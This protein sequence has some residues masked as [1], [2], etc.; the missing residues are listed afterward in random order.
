[1]RIVIGEDSVLLRAG[2]T[3]LLAESRSGEF[4]KHALALMKLLEQTSGTELQRAELYNEL[5]MTAPEGDPQLAERYVAEGLALLGDRSDAP[6]RKARGLLLT[7]RGNMLTRKSEFAASVEPFTQARD[8]LADGFADTTY[9]GNVLSSLGWIEIRFDRYDS[10][11]SYFEQAAEATRRDPTAFPRTLAMRYDDLASAKTLVKRYADAERNFRMAIDVLERSYGRDD[12]ETAVTI[13]K[14]GRALAMQTRYD[15]AIAS[16]REAV[17]ILEKP[18]PHSNA[19]YLANARDFLVVTLLQAGRL[20]EAEPLV[21][22]LVESPV[23]APA[24]DQANMHVVAAEYFAQRGDLASAQKHARA[25]LDAAQAAYGEGNPKLIRFRNR[26]ARLLLV[27]G[28]AEQASQL[29]IA[30]MK[31]DAANEG[32]FDSIWRGAHLTHKQALVFLGRGAQAVPSLERLL[33]QHYAQ[34]KEQQDPV[35]EHAIEL[36]LGRALM[37]AGRQ[38]EAL[39]HLERALGLRQSQY[40]FSPQLAEAKIALADCKLRLGDVNGS[41]ALLA[42]AEAIH[43]ANRALAA[44]YRAPLRNL[45]QRLRQFPRAPT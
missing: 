17:Q 22:R 35:Q 27:L 42:E 8:L 18:H 38:T 14:L 43:A 45:Q 40:R 10:A 25:F 30:N 23:S 1:V 34:P 26:W 4:S 39:P 19:S 21:R 16:L 11:L 24:F 15:E 9:Y 5:A 3:R 29:A 37:A 20:D 44:Y 6:H 28:Q 41:R 31:A 13:L 33:E 36:E 2:I 32:V 7:T 12:P